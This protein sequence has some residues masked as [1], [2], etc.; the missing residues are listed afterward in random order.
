MNELFGRRHGDPDRRG[1]ESAPGELAPSPYPAGFVRALIASDHVTAPTRHALQSR[2]H[3]ELDPRCRFFAE[4]DLTILHAICARL[5][6]QNDLLNPVDIA[7]FIDRRL[8]SA[9]GDG[10]R[11][12]GMPPDAEAW[13]TGMS[14][15][16][17]TSHA[18]FSRSFVALGDEHQDQVLGCIQSGDAPSEIWGR[19][20]PATFFEAML[21][22]TVEAFYAHP[23]AQEDIGYAGMADGPGWSPIGL[24]QLSAREPRRREAPVD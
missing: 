8:A 14:A 6:P 18:R 22:W 13:T 10:W 7:G 16:E 20:D 5:V 2:L 11:Y 24:D 12:A 4:N 1:D 3:P 17:A 21:V 9:A 23:T 19:I 15:I